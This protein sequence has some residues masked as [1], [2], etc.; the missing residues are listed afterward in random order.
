MVAMVHTG[1]SMRAVARAYQVSLCTVQRWMAR[2]AAARLDRVE[3]ND[4]A[5]IP[6]RSHRTNSATEDL[7]LRLRRELKET[8]DLGEYGARAIHRALIERCHPVVP[9]PRTVGRILERRGAFDGRRRVRRLPPPRGWYL[10][11]VA[12]RHAELDSFDVVE[13]LVIQGGTEVEVLTTVSLHGGLVGAWPG[14]PVTAKMVVATLIDHWRQVGL[15]AFAQFDND[16]RFQGAHQFRDSISRVMRLCLSLGV[17]PV[18]AP[19]NEPAFQAALENLNGQWQVKVW[20]R[21]HHDD[22]PALCERSDRY[23]RASRVRSAAR[24]ET[25]PRRHAF[26]A[27]WEFDLQAAL[28]GLLIFLR[29]TTERGAVSLLGRTFEVDPHW[30]HRLVRCEV[31]LDRERLRFYA[32]RRRQPESQPMLGETA[33]TVPRR[34]F[35][36]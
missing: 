20:A 16:T 18:F 35:H 2:A 4:R 10:P 29:R 6:Q 32:L 5:P 14:P 3:W 33:Y 28:H 24:I 25:A 21:F 7:V 27:S 17:V 9:S 13:G 19:V 31:D 30:S 15:P 12:E 1:A 36:E 23:V 26:P 8:S 22:I 34:R 11:S